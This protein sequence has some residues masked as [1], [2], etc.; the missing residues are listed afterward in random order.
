[1]QRNFNFTKFFRIALISAIFINGYAPIAQTQWHQWGGPNRNF[2]AESVQLNTDWPEDGPKRLW[3]HELGDGNSAIVFDDDVLYT[4][5]RRNDD[6]III[7]LNAQNGEILWEHTHHAPLWPKFNSGYGPGPHGTP[8]VVD[9]YVYTVGVRADLLCLNKKTGEAIWSH[10]L[11]KEFGAKPTDRGYSSSAIAYKGMLILPVGGKRGHGV[12]AFDLRDGHVIWKSQNFGSTF[13]SPII[14]NVDGQDQLVIFEGKLVAGFDPE[15]GKL[16]W[17][18][19]HRTKYDINASTP[20]WGEGNL[21]FI[22]SAYDAGSRV[23]HLAQN[24]GKTSVKEMWFSRKMKIQHG[25]AVR[26]G[27]TIYG[28]S[29]DSGPAFLMGANA[30]T[31]E[32]T[33]KQRGFAKA[34]VLAVGNKLIVLDEDGELAIVTA[35]PDGFDIHAKAQVLTTRAW[36]VPTLVG[37]TLYLRDRKEIVALDLSP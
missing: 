1:M 7:A 12:M 16:L 29:G 13:S 31:G 19:P 30:E 10:D 24:N 4:M 3:N 8:L 20:V 14:I 9:D 25:T 11:R 15:T 5:Y 34:N 33:A 28:S 36:T 21:L 6:E 35:T 32:M 23:L 2:T 37:T 22:S 17:K 27:D 18:H 26:I